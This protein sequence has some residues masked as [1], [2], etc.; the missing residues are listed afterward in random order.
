MNINLDGV[1]LSAVQHWRVTVK[2]TICSFVVDEQI[3]LTVALP[4]AT[5]FDDDDQHDDNGNNTQQCT[6]NDDNNIYNGKKRR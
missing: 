6:R 2:V 5:I 1:T 4:V 3:M